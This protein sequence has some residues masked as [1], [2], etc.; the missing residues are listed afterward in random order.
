[1]L[2][3]PQIFSVTPEHAHAAAARLRSWLLSAQV[4]QREGA[5][6]GGVAGVLDARGSASYVYPEIT[7]YYLHWLAEARDATGLDEARVAAARAAD[8]ARRQLEDGK[9]PATRTYLVDA[10][11]DWRNGASFFFDLAMLLRG[12]CAAG[13]A[14]LIM[15]PHATLHRLVEEL[16][17]FVSAEGEIHAVRALHSSAEL[18]TRWS[19]L[20][21]PF[22]VKASSRV[23]LAARHV[24]LPDRLVAACEHHAERYLRSAGTL[25][26]DMLHPTLYFAE[27]MLVAR[28]RSAPA[29]A[30]LLQR[31]LDLQHRDGSLPEAEF[32]TSVPRS[33]II[34]QALRIGLLL[35][36]DGVAGAP[37]PQVLGRLAGALIERVDDN[38]RI[39][40][41]PD[42]EMAY[43]NVWCG[44]FAE[45]AL[46]WYARWREG[47][48]LPVA[49]WLV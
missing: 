21:G 28:P 45:Q 7:G 40:F 32:A 12:L 19:T 38:G 29:I 33:D 48:L 1:M 10:P 25:A 26:L 23:A 36:A 46:R 43:P 42:S 3:T 16:D 35:C 18:P 13:E 14:H 24:V 34:A 5:H 47:N 20:G 6:A 2:L 27:G 44:M 11:A 17:R 4:Q 30:E 22:E 39:A 9:L 37:E 15:L 49:E 31:C 8:W 41:V